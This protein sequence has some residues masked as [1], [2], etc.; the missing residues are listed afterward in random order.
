MY[1][2]LLKKF[3]PSNNRLLEKFKYTSKEIIKY[4]S[5]PDS[6]FSETTYKVTKFD[7]I[8]KAHVNTNLTES[9]AQLRDI[10]YIVLDIL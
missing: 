5:Y 1:L 7:L 8:M 10:F 4:S 2:E 3:N 9:N 6:Q